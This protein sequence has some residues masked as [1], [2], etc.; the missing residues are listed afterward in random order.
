MKWR[1]TYT[2]PKTGDRRIKEK[3]ALFPT[4]CG[5]YVVWLETYFSAQE[6]VYRRRATKFGPIHCH[7]WDEVKRVPK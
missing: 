5:D 7:A 3:F 4:T 6:Y 2:P 1:N